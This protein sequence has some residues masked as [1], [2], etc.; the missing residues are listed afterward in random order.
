MRTLVALASLGMLTAGMLAGCA[1]SKQAPVSAE[2]TSTVTSLLGAVDGSARPTFDALTCGSVFDASGNDLVAMWADATVRDVSAA[3][4]RAAGIKAGWQPQVAEGFDLVLIGPHE[5]KFA[6]K[7]DKVRAELAKCSISGRHQELSIDLRPDL[8]AEQ[9]RAM[10]PGFAAAARAA[11][12]VAEIAGE[13]VDVKTFPASGQITDAP[14]V[15]LTTCGAGG[16]ARGARW[17]AS[18]RQGITAAPDLKQRVLDYLGPEWTVD[19]REGQPGYLAASRPADQ[20]GFT[21]SLR[22][23]KNAGAEMEL[24]AN[25]E[26]V[27]VAGP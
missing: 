13:P 5:V 22:T 21:V 10:S 12:G 9:Q 26:C 1:E 18:T 23:P 3:E 7:G 20:V 4:L 6:L 19:P 11:K 14:D 25:G 15:S 27:L 8:T 16:G 17:Y 2:F 24:V